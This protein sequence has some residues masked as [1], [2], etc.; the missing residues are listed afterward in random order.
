[1][2]VWQIGQVITCALC[3]NHC[4]CYQTRSL[5]CTVATASVRMR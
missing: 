1:M 3:D 5:R 4:S 2:A